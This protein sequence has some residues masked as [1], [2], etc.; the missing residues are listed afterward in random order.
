MIDVTRFRKEERDFVTA[1]INRLDNG[2]VKHVGTGLLA[3]FVQGLTP[4]VFQE[5]YRLGD[6]LCHGDGAE[7]FNQALAL[8][9]RSPLHTICVGYALS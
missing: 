8:E 7:T 1:I 2:D 3:E 5:G 9:N 4:A 6:V